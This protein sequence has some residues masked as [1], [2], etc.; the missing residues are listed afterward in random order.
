MKNEKDI[1]K[2][3][4]ELEEEREMASDIHLKDKLSYG[5]YILEWMMRENKG[6]EDG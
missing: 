5:I 6:C 1:I 4:K 3:I 2:K